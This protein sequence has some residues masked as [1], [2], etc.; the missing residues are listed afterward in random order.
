MT[1]ESSPPRLAQTSLSRN[2]RR[3]LRRAPR[4]SG[5]LK[6][7][8]SERRRASFGDL[9]ILLHG[10]SA[11]PDGAHYFA[12]S[13]QGDAPGEYDEA[14]PVGVAQAEDGAARLRVLLQVRRLLLEGDGGV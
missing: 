13:H 2:S 6:S 1:R 14:P 11:H 9:L 5:G 7:L 10:A 4:K 8:R 3:A 12:L